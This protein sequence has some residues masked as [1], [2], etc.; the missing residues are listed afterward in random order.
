MEKWALE[1]G[2]PNEMLRQGLRKTDVRAGTDLTVQGHL[3]KEGIFT[4]PTAHID[5]KTIK[6]PG[7]QLLDQRGEPGR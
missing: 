3:A 1:L 5:S 4:V 7:G 2:S 6:L